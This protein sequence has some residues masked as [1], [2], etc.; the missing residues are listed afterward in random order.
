MDTYNEKQ[1]ML[2]RLQDFQKKLNREPNANEVKPTPDGKAK[3]LAISFVEMTLDELFF[4]QWDT[5]N[6]KWQAIANEVQGSLELVVVHPVTGKFI[7][8]VGA[9]SVII[10][11]D[12]VPDSIKDNQQER[13]RWAL[14]PSNKK[15]NAL[16]LSFPKLKSE[17]LKNAAQSLGKVFGRDL[18]RRESDQYNAPMKE[19]SKGAFDALV[20]RLESGDSKALILAEANFILTEEQKEILKGC[21]PL[22]QIA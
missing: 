7:T 17:C 6:F 13:N 9:A 10:T 19:I 5:Q 1:E 14:D 8:R 22:K 4:G 20:K 16:D 15:P 3:S 18:N 11:V 21:L 12:K 2:L